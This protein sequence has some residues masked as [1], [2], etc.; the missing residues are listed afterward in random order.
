MFPSQGRVQMVMTGLLVVSIKPLPR[1]NRLLASSV[2]LDD[3][4]RLEPAPKTLS[5]PE[6]LTL[7]SL[8]G[9]ETVCGRMSHW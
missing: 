4:D 9:S 1:V 3:H 7:H 2:G 8:V 6:D 5:H